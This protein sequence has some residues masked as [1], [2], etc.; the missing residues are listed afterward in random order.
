[1]SKTQENMDLEYL[2]NRVAELEQQKYEFEFRRKSLQESENI[3]SIITRTSS[4]AIFIIQNEKISFMNKAAE[5]LFELSLAEIQNY[6]LNDIFVTEDLDLAQTGLKVGDSVLEDSEIII[7]NKNKIEKLINLTATSIFY[8]GKPALLCTGFDISRY[9]TPEDHRESEIFNEIFEVLP[10]GVWR[11]DEFGKIV[12][13]NKANKEIW[14]VNRKIELPELMKLKRWDAN[15]GNELPVDDWCISKAVNKGETTIEQVLDIETFKGN[16]KT[17]TSIAAPFFEDG[18]VAGAIGINYD[19]TEKRQITEKLNQ[20]AAILKFSDNA[21]IGID[22]DGKV[23]SWNFGAEKIYGY[24]E[25]EILG[26]LFSVLIPVNNFKEFSDTVEKVKTGSKIEHYETKRIRKDGN[27]IDI[28]AAVSPIKDRFENVIGVASIS[29]DITEQKSVSQSVQASEEKFRRMFEEGPVGIGIINLN[30]KFENVN[31]KYCEMVGYS[32]EELITKTF[33]DITH[34]DDVDVDVEL[35]K[36]LSRGEIPFYKIEKRYVKK[37]GSIFWIE[38][39][40]SV[41]KNEKN[42]PLFYIAMVEDINIRK[43]AQIKITESEERYR[44]LAKNFPNGMVMLYDHAMNLIIAEGSILNKI[45]EKTGALEGKNISEVFP[46]KYV[47]MYKPNLEAALKGEESNILMNAGNKIFDVHALPIKSGD[48]VVIAGMVMIQDV[49][50]LK[51]NEK[52]LE[53]LNLSKDKFFSIIAHD[54]KNPFTS[55]LGFSE[56]LLSEI[57]ELEKSDIKDLT[58]TIFKSAKGIYNLLENLLQWA[59]LQSNKAEINP[60]LINLKEMIYESVSIFQ[61]NAIKKKIEINCEI[62]NDIYCYADQNMIETAVRNL[63]SNAVKFTE[64]GGEV[65]ISTF[66][67]EDQTVVE[68]VDTG[69][70]I[71]PENLENLFR[72]DRNF[73]TAGTDKERGTGLGL[74]LCK[75]FIEKNGG[76]ISVESEIGKGSK[77]TFSVPKAKSTAA[78]FE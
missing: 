32:K 66:E 33:V 35:A 9:K 13:M 36:Q 64:Q 42:E 24:K 63:I 39:S 20:T 15:T 16:R 38:L 65:K 73:S 75:E 74:I 25:S 62:E 1:M 43:T 26:K 17:I 4:A 44:T 3:L 10:V 77:F 55:L 5:N 40:G 47:S 6:S 34:P 18:K 49:T 59:K 54:L 31:E 12:F 67:K 30:F 21:I 48:G 7:Q 50:V 60:R 68:V 19:V 69:K 8:K 27:I 72:I 57:D 52:L 2:K 22:L 41:V 61:P 78:I 58:A 71:S 46:E 11:S 14:D 70:G 37:D 53:E 51:E 45:K 56:I 76:K 29:H 28:Y 23:M